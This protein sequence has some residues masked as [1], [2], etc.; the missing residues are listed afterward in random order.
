MTSNEAILKLQLLLDKTGS[1]YFTTDEYLS[2]LNMSQLEFINRLFP[3]TLGGIAN[4]ELDE[5]TS[6]TVAPLIYRLTSTPS[7]GIV[8][9]SSLNTLLQSASSDNTTSVFRVA[10]LSTVSGNRPVRFTK[11]N[12][13]NVDLNNSFKT[14]TTTDP[15]YIITATNYTIYPTSVGAVNFTVLKTPRILTS[16]NSPDFDDYVMN[17]VIQIAYQLATVATRDESGIQLGTNTT[18]QSK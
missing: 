5:N 14:P 17:Q 13:I 10:S 18:I 9:K 4:F 2:F 16:V 11:H 6:A 15:R 8:T 7:L 1:P 12:N 3:D